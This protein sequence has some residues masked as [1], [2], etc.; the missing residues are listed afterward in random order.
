MPAFGAVQTPTTLSSGDKLAVLNVENLGA[1][2]LTMVFALAPQP[3]PPYLDIYNNTTSVINLM[4]SP[5][6]V[7][8]HF[9]PVFD[10]IAGVQI[11][12]QPGNVLTAQPHGG[13]YYALQAVSA[14]TAGTIW[15]DR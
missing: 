13:L 6:L 10:G 8:A 12:A 14:V 15:V 2:G 7:L 1:G 5:D 11:Q 4:A 3:A 9:L